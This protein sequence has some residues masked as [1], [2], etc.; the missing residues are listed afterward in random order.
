MTGDDAHEKAAAFLDGFAQHLL[1]IFARLDLLL[2]E[3]DHAPG[4]LELA[5]NVTG[6]I[7]IRRRVADEDA[8]AGA[9]FFLMFLVHGVRFA[10]RRGVLLAPTIMELRD[11]IERIGGQDADVFG[12]PGK[13]DDDFVAVCWLE[14]FENEQIAASELRET[15][16][17]DDLHKEPQEPVGETQTEHEEVA[18]LQSFAQ[19][20]EIRKLLIQP[21]EK[22]EQIV[23]PQDEVTGGSGAAKYLVNETMF[24]FSHR[25]ELP[26]QIGAGAA[27]RSRGA[28]FFG[29]AARRSTLDGARQQRIE[30]R[31]DEELKSLDG[32][33]RCES[34]AG[35]QVWIFDDVVKPPAYAL[36]GQVFRAL[37][38][39]D[40][41]QIAR[42]LVELQWR[43]KFRGQPLREH[44]VKQ[45]V[46]ASERHRTR[47]DN[48]D[49]LALANLSEKSIPKGI[50]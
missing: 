20:R 15:L 9:V 8:T 43:V 5:H 22:V 12:E 18:L 29:L 46:A 48:R 23:I 47:T 27:Q 45:L 50:V 10:N 28:T 41:L 21:Q 11:E 16:T 31:A 19:F 36:H 35:P 4:F 1:P 13:I 32:R 25:R 2:V 17:L 7:Q 40:F 39:H 34:C 44:R 24:R 49:N 33:Q 30:C 42:R 6:N 14:F 26:G 38:I 3:P 37:G